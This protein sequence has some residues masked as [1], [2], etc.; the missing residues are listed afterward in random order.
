[1]LKLPK[2]TLNSDERWCFSTATCHKLSAGKLEGQKTGYS[3]RGKTYCIAKYT[4]RCAKKPV[5]HLASIDIN[6]GL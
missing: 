1:M 6:Q 2:E 4:L 3:V 5:E